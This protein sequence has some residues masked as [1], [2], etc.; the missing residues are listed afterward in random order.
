MQLTLHSIARIFGWCAVLVL[1]MLCLTAS[2][3]HIVYFRNKLRAQAL[4]ND[5]RTLRVGVSSSADV[6]RIVEKYGGIEYE[7]GSADPGCPMPDISYYAGVTNLLLNR[8]G[9]RFP[10]L[11]FV[12]RPRGAGTDF[13]VK[14]GKL[15]YLQY[16]VDTYPAP[17][18]WR[19]TVS[20][21]MVPRETVGFPYDHPMPYR[22]F[23][24]GGN[25]S[26]LNA[27]ATADASLE[28]RRKAFAFDLSCLSTFGGCHVACELL[29]S[30][31]LDWQAHGN[32]SPQQMNEPWCEKSVHPQ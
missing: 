28:D 24:A 19:L 2:F 30:A 27:Q 29:P 23:E 31:W 12:I 10:S 5:V 15:C 3:I 9:M 1:A 26:I 11:W 25:H 18:Q 7:G 20:G 6:Q 21:T 14:D 17:H 16:A 32:P 4:L 22:S 8:L 13:F